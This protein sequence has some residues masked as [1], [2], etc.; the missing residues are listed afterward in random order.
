MAAVPRR[1][2]AVA[3]GSATETEKEQ[4]EE[5]EAGTARREGHGRSAGVGG[6]RR[7][8]RPPHG[9]GRRPCLILSFSTLFSSL[10]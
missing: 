10:G 6:G 4:Q 3:M 1:V 7:D 8:G 5:Q 2:E 9:Q